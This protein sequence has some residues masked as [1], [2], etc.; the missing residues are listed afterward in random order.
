MRSRSGPIWQRNRRDRRQNGKRTHRLGRTRSLC[1]SVRCLCH[2][3]QCTFRVPYSRVHW[4]SYAV[5]CAADVPVYL[6]CAVC[7]SVPSVC[8][9]QSS[10]A[11]FHWNSYAVLCA[12]RASVPCVP[13]V[14]AYRVMTAGTMLPM[15]P[16]PRFDRSTFTLATTTPT[17]ILLF[18]LLLR[19]F[20]HQVVS[21]E[22][23]GTSGGGGWR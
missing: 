19:F 13:Y 17:T 23:N 21:G 11:E 1:A 12:I 14:P 8:H 18:F 22:A 7:A 9:M 16:P 15:Y 10:Y 6:P 2:T 3:S 20:F 4:N 5:L